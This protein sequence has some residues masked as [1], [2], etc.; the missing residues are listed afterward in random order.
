MRFAGEGFFGEGVV[1][2]DFFPRR[3]GRPNARHFAINDELD[4]AA[5]DAFA[6]GG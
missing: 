3:I 4:D 6:A 1:P 5:A 2:R